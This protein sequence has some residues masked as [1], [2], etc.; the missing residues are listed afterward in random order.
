V[1]NFA[2]SLSRLTTAPRLRR[3]VLAGGVVLGACA[4]LLSAAPAGAIVESVGGTAVGLQPRNVATFDNG[5][6]SGEF[7]DAAGG[8]ILPSTNTYIVYWDPTNTFHGNWE[9][10][11][12]AYMQGMGAESGDLASVFAVDSQYTD[13]L[14]QHASYLS[15]FHGAYT[16][17]NHYPTTGTCTDP[18]PLHGGKALTC[19]TDKQIREQLETFLA[20][21]KLPKG[22][23]S[24]YYLLTPPGVAVCLEAGHCSDYPA[25]PEQIEFDEAEGLEPEA[26]E[27]YKHSFCSYHSAI[28]PDNSTTGDAS[29]VLYA[30]IPW[31]AGGAGDFHL[32]AQDRTQA[33]DCQDGGFF[34]N[35]ETSS[36]EKESAAVNSKEEAEKRL[37]AE[38]TE[39]AELT[40]AEEQYEKGLITEAELKARKT[41]LK[42]A[43]TLREAE[44]KTAREKREKSEGP[45]EQEPNQDG[46]GEDGSYDTGL[47]DL[48]VS[49]IGVEQ[50][51]IV[52]D[53]LLNGWHDSAGN[54]STDECRNFFA[55][56]LGGSLA[57]LSF[58]EAGT[59]YNQSLNTSAYINDA[60]DL[61]AL[62]DD[63]PGIPCING[64]NL[65][66]RFTAPN[67]VNAGEVVGF[68][69][70]ESDITLDAGV[71]F[72][73]KGVEEPTWPI[74]TWNFGDGTPEI[75]GFAPGAPSSNSPEATPCETPWL[76]PCAASTYHTY[77]YGGTYT[78][79]LTVSDVA[80]HTASESEQVTVAGPPRPA[81]S[82]T[83]GGSSSPG[84]AST[85]TGAPGTGAGA[86]A[87]GHAPVPPPVAAAAIPK[88]TLHSA[89]RKGLV[90]SY[91]VNEQVAGHF[92]VLL[93]SATAHRLGISGAPAV[94][95]PAGSPAEVVIAK[96]ILVTTKGGHSAVH[97]AFSK[98]T[99]ARLAHVHKV[100]LMLRLIVRNAASIDPLT[101]SVVSSATLNA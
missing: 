98:L 62:K 22:T 50:Q 101:T 8:P 15:S 70:M 31:I 88:Q 52:T 80:G 99:D 83:A 51:N 45:H 32:S 58:T 46:R 66:P 77:Q 81:P 55:P 87:A 34:F 36:M 56:T 74:F 97:I 2:R 7:R 39:I 44:E 14:N 53:P 67:P 42:T 78:V 89:V 9:H 64:V 69:G 96:A 40:A 73:A 3:R 82:G 60:F 29:T 90:V 65:V 11:V 72:S 94:G 24:V 57:P 5:S 30:V 28:N 26:R 92:E 41:Q 27:I 75:S 76:S 43:R 68:D 48:L 38:N 47:A 19:L 59:T 10:I 21:H 93:S 61:A 1:R 25:T 91:S 23:Q 85:S 100:S 49:Q 20:Q 13:P 95:L 79:T 6:V 4:G 86:A 35:G 37:A 54:E 84:T 12:N 71:K 16:D 18:A 33:Y 17:T 63:Y